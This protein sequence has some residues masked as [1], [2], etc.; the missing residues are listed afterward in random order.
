MIYLQEENDDYLL[1]DSGQGGSASTDIFLV[2]RSE[3]DY[4]IIQDF[5]GGYDTSFAVKGRSLY[6]LRLF[7]RGV[8]G[9]GFGWASIRYEWS[10]KQY[11]PR[12]TLFEYI[13]TNTWVQF[14]NG[15]CPVKAQDADSVKFYEL[16]KEELIAFYNG[17]Y[18]IGVIDPGVRA[19]IEQMKGDIFQVEKFISWVGEDSVEIMYSISWDNRYLV[20]QRRQER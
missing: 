18:E 10:G 20:M 15:V 14:G 5:F 6:D 3:G 17:Y 4:E 1:F 12:D 7:H 9:T 16:N 11:I 2:K 19:K 8:I 13:G